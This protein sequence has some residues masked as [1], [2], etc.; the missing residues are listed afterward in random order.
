MKIETVL[1]SMGEH[2][3]RK[4]FLSETCV[5]TLKALDSGVVE[6]DRLRQIVLEKVSQC[7]M[8]RDGMIRA[9]LITSLTGKAVEALARDLRIQ[10]GTGDSLYSKVGR[11]RFRRGSERERALFKFFEVAWEDE[12]CGEE[13]GSAGASVRPVST[14]RPSRPLF[15]HQLAAVSG[16]RERLADP[17]SRVLLH[18][19]TGAGK[20]RMAM[21]YVADT[22]VGDP[23]ALVVWLA[24]SEELCEQ[25][26]EE[27]TDTWRG[28]GSRDAQ[29]YRFYGTHEPDLLADDRRSGLVVA[30]LSKTH[31]HAQRHDQFLT[32]LADRVS[33]VVM[34]EA[35]QA[36]A[37]TYRFILDSLVEKHGARLLGLSATP[38]RTWN[39]RLKDGE[40]ADFFGRNKVTIG[41]GE[42][43]GPIDFLIR[44]GF[45]ARQ[46]TERLVYKDALTGDDLAGLGLDV[47]IPQSVLDKLA[48]DVARNIMIVS[49][50]E[51]L[52]GRGHTRIIYFAASVSNARDMS[53][54]LHARRHDSLFIDASTPAGIR[55]RAIAEYRSDSAEPKIVCNFGV[56][57]AGF[58]A[59]RTTA[60]LIARPT[61]SLVL[62]SQMVG[63]AIRGP[64]VGGS[65]EC[66]VVT[67]VDTSLPG[68]DSMVRSFGNWED[69]WD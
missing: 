5:E 53:L 23:G 4:V 1:V 55:G 26:V 6:P 43:E 14:V 47:D 44:E 57:T 49:K 29:V 27:F 52:I 50:I 9:A 58:D 37:E 16:I 24:H 3:L 10:R 67:V 21:R 7:S 48:G 25:A 31:R 8:L 41:A 66:T 38:G 2:K 60:V 32:T 59:P 63:R 54:A 40:L 64:R 42:G 36:I 61:K 68:F 20:T 65:E 35:H 11:M 30:G 46:R 19:P 45:I 51:E 18:M 28:V 12:E 69:V 15:D 33:L 39:N 17:G 62:Y 22:L 56:L 34:D 13:E